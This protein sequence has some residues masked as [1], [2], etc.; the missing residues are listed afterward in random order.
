MKPFCQMNQV[1][2]DNENEISFDYCS[3]DDPNKLNM[4]MHHNPFIL[5]L[6]ISSL[7]LHID[8]LKIFLSL[9]TAKLDIIHY[10]IIH[11]IGHNTYVH[12]C[13]HIMCF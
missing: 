1:F 12:I 2:G 11:Y 3:I 9:L 13:G 10:V 4:N 6:N 7:Y 8:D 5:H